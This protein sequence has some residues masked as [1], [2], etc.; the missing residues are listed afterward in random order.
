MNY[1]VIIYGAGG[2]GREILSMIQSLPGCEVLGFADDLVTTGSEI[3]GL[4]ILGGIKYLNALAS[5]TNVILAFGDPSIKALKV[6]EI[7]NKRIHFPVLVHATAVLQDRASIVMGKGTI[8]CAGAVLTTD[9]TIGSHVLV[10]L[11]STIGH[12]S[13]IGDCTSLMPGV[14]IAGGVS[15]GNEVLV[16]A[17]SSLINGITVGDKSKIGMGSVVIRDVGRDVMVAG[18][19]AKPIMTKPESKL[20]S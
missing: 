10:N 14:N 7:K 15:I 16:G 13:R 20:Q 8:V 6:N 19:P 17:G 12:D 1:P 9:I 2:L 18:V 3:K 5:D 4:K 11:N